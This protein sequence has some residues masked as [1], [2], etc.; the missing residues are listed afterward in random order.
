MAE[1]LTRTER[2]RIERR[3]GADL[4]LTTL[5]REERRDAAV[6]TIAHTFA[7][8]VKTGEGARALLLAL[9]EIFAWVR[10]LDEEEV[11]DML[12]EL[13]DAVR[14]AA[15]PDVFGPLNGVV[16]GWKPRRGSR[17][18]LMSTPR[19]SSF[20]LTTT[21]TSDRWS[22]RDT[23][24][25]GSGGAAALRGRVALDFSSREL[26]GELALA[27]PAAHHQRVERE[28]DRLLSLRTPTT[29]RIPSA[30]P[31]APTAA[32]CLNPWPPDCPSEGAATV[33]LLQ[34]TVGS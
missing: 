34:R 32:P 18:T 5:E 10:H 15:D 2:L 31:A 29:A 8:L 6:T 13:V 23:Q 26:P 22:L 19:P 9:P 16:A 33:T 21:P 7:A 11:R 12:V 1:R 25:R 14:D 24:E 30:V 27:D 20:R 28:D 3:D 17:P 4:V